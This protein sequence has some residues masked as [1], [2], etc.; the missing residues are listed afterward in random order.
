MITQ[1]VDVFSHDVYHYGDL[2]IQRC[3]NSSLLRNVGSLDVEK[4]L[5]GHALLQAAESRDQDVREEN[6][7][8]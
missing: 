7:I 3:M 8:G 6:R 4:S 5:M 1:S 2:S